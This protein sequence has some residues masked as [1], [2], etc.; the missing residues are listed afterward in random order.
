[1]LAALIAI[2]GPGQD[3]IRVV[4]L[5]LLVDGGTE[6]QDRGGRHPVGGEATLGLGLACKK[7]RKRSGMR[8]GMSTNQLLE[9]LLREK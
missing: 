4:L 1:M 7:R 5:A 3:V 6:A 2:S 8:L 9:S